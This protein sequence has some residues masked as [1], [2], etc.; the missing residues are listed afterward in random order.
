M[1]QFSRGDPQSAFR[2]GLDTTVRGMSAAKHGESE[3]LILA[4]R[5]LPGLDDSK[6]AF[7]TGRL[8][9]LIAQLFDRA[10]APARVAL[11]FRE[12][13]SLA[14]MA[15]RMRMDGPRWRTADTIEMFLEMY[16]RTTNCDERALRMIETFLNQQVAQSASEAG[17]E[18]AARP[19]YFGF[20]NRAAA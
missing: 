11:Q 1:V 18:P 8:L 4:T 6:T 9:R 17:F 2:H 12:N 20:F 3:R 5:R 16:R 10:H 19:R 15:S 14:V 13:L 7:E